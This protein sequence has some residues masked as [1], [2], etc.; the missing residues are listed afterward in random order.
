M[1][2]EIDKLEN[3]NFWVLYDTTTGK[4]I[5]FNDVESF[6]KAHNLLRRD[7]KKEWEK[8]YLI[9]KFENEICFEWDEEDSIKK[10]LKKIN[11]LFALSEKDTNLGASEQ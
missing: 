3:N 1:G 9:N 11:K 5:E 10:E 6:Q 2:V 4:V 8:D 7:V